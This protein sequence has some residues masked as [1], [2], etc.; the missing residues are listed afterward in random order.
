MKRC[1]NIHADNNI[2]LTKGLRQNS[3]SLCAIFST[4]VDDHS[5]PQLSV[6]CCSQDLQPCYLLLRG[7]TSSFILSVEKVEQGKVNAHVIGCGENGIWR[8][9]CLCDWMRLICIIN[10]LNIYLFSFT[11]FYTR[12][13]F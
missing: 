1:D 9:G 5:P 7:R 10:Q 13:S 3:L 11:I 6:L 8:G 12:K 4:N 2:C